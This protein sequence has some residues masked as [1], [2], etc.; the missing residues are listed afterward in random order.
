MWYIF[1]GFII[2]ISILV[3]IFVIRKN[4]DKLSNIDTAKTK[5]QEKQAE[6]KKKLLESK[7]DQ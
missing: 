3:I 4:V 1:F 7:L 5:V 2:T 6:I